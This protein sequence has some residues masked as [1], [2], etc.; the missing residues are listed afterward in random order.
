MHCLG[1]IQYTIVIGLEI[2]HKT[3]NPREPAK[4]KKCVYEREK[5]CEKN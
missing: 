5:A 4:R 3:H 2:S 1:R